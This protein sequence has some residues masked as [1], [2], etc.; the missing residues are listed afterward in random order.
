MLALDKKKYSRAGI[1]ALCSMVYFV[2][3]FS[4]KD[5][6]VV[7][8][9]MISE[10]AIDRVNAGLV[11][12][13]LFAFYG[14]GQLLSGYL[15][16]KIKPKYLI[17][18]GLSVTAICNAL[19]PFV[20]EGLMIAVWGINGLAQAM[21]WPPIVK[22]LSHYLDHQTY[23]TANLVVTAA[24][25]VATVLLYAFV[26]LCLTFMS[27]ESV[28]IVAAIL[29]FASMVVFAIAMRIILPECVEEKEIKTEKEQSPTPVSSKNDCNILSVMKESG[30]FTVFICIIV[31]GFLRDGIESWL[32][33]LYSEAFGRDVS[34]STLVSIILPIFSIVSISVVTAL[35]RKKVF[36]NEVSGSAIL[37]GLSLVSAI[38]L[39]IFV[40]MDGTF[41][42]IASLFLTAFVCSAMHGAN[43]LLI[44]CLP[45]RFA[46]FGRAATV[47]GVCNSCV[48]IGAAIST[49][50]IALVSKAMG[51]SVTVVTWCGILALGI[52]FAFLS[53]KRYTAMIS[54]DKE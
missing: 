17:M 52:L 45:G 41:F 36:R 37:F 32:P 3:Y 19:M 14:I 13:M 46:K 22:I 47:S 1:I 50:G 4:R 6:A 51:W 7:M 38:P 25:H 40:S 5:F 54:A 23:V 42:G 24:A 34:E 53:Y 11:G 12:T 9:G 28:F 31:V 2:S 44:S 18:F 26:P 33:M 39:A 10:G 15:G 30:I 43:F 49:Y 21:L 29:A 48:Y 8:A 35:H 27:W 16:D 20:P